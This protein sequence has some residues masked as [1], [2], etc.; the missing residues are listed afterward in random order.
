MAYIQI[1][2]RGGKVLINDG[3]RYQKNKVRQDTIYW[4]CWRKTCN[5]YLKTNAFDLAA[6]NPN[7]RMLGPPGLPDH[8]HGDDTDVIQTSALKI[9]MAERV[10]AD[11]SKP[12]KRVYDEVVADTVEGEQVSIPEFSHVRSKLNR[13]KAA[14]FPPI[15]NDVE[16]LVIRDEWAESW[17]GSRFLSLQ[18]NAWGVMVFATD[19]NLHKLRR[20]PDIYM[21]GTFKSCPRPY[22]QFV[23]IHGKYLGRVVP[24]VMCLMTE[25]TVAQ[26]RQV[27]AHVK[28]KVQ[29]VTGHRW[30]PQRIVT[31]F[32]QS[33]LLAIETELP[34]T[35]RSGCYFHFCQSLWRKVQDLGLA[36]PYR[37]HRALRNLVQKVMAIGYLPRALVRQNF[38][39]LKNERAT[40]RL[41]RRHHR[42]QEFLQYMER[43]Y[44]NAGC[45]FPPSMW[46]VFDRT[47]DNRTNNFVEGKEFTAR[48]LLKMFYAFDK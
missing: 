17:G 1:G 19:G 12:V 3:H 46:N 24:L 31:D 38:R 34:G 20:C 14:L 30:R 40:T 29:V 2:N 37:R 18:D 9:V 10:A 8:N 13:K 43:N 22:H 7:I 11:P 45:Q 35:K 25:K 44:V 39:V 27:L 41:I 36:R 5:A 21:D 26:Y 47:N 48:Y 4:R 33:L 23:T 15:P 42:L 16:D 32:E 28:S 6:Q